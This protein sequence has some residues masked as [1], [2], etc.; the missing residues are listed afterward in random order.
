MQNIFHL[1]N[2]PDPKLIEEFSQYGTAMIADSMGRY[3]AMM[4]YI[5]PLRRGIRIAGP[6]VTVQTYRSDNLMLHV[7]LELAEAGDVLVANAGEVE[8]AGLWGDLMTRMAL[9]KRLGGLVIDGAVRDSEQLCQSGF[10]VFSKSV[11]PMGGFKQSAGSVN[12]PISCGG[13]MVNPG[14][15]I[16]GDDDGVVVIP[17][18]RAQEVLSVCK[19][20]EAKE[21]AIIRGMEE[22]RSLFELLGLPQ[23]L[24]N[25]GLELPERGEDHE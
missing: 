14:D 2:R 10:A 20:T 1:K 13:V 19:K 24:K 21:A 12:V 3:G 22:G 15:I 4:P 23:A 7:G 16:I 25:L 9:Q 17:R 11:C 8:N 18:E 5:R 6:A